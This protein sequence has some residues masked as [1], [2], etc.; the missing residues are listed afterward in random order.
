MLDT[1]N[2]KVGDKVGVGGCGE[3]A[4]IKTVARRTATQV[5]LDDGSR[6]NQRGRKVGNAG[7]SREWLLTEQEAQERNADAEK[8]RKYN[9]LVREVREI[10]LRSISEDGLRMMLQ[11]AK[12]Y[13][14]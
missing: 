6:W 10:A 2:L 3:M 12:D 5:I 4:P 14:L 8:R 11:V 9:E 1:S 13:Q 7:Y